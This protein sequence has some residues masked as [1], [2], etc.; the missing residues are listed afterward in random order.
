MVDSML[1]LE[2]LRPE[3]PRL[4]TSDEFERLCE[5]GVFDDEH[6]ELL[7]G[8]LVAMGEQGEPH[9][10]VAAWLHKRLLLA[11]G[12]EYEIRSHSSYVAT[13]DS[14]PEPDVQVLK[15]SLRRHLPRQ[16]LLLIEVSETSF[17][18]DSRIK[19]PIYGENRAPEYW[20]VDL[21]NQAVWVHT[22]PTRQG[23]RRV[24]RRGSGDVLHP[25]A[26]PDVE[27]AVA[28]IPW[29]PRPVRRRKAS[30]R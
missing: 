21:P 5:T 9:A 12:D 13:H 3:K 22:Q 11:V 29:H 1:D 2:V 18:K 8:V 19:A 30:G 17:G 20:I 10:R 7:R 14:V 6:V 23:Y 16:A 4:L 26:V 15:H 25:V 28:D 24:V 27:I